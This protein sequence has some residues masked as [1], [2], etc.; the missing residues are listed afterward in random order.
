MSFPIVAEAV[1]I[2]MQ[3]EVDVE[4]WTNNA[5]NSP[6]GERSRRSGR[7]TAT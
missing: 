4:M 2:E 3:A 1:H 7:V 6:V 5:S